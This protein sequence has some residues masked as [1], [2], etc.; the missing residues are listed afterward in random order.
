MTVGAGPDSA[1]RRLLDWVA[2]LGPR[3]G[4]P[5]D[6]CR[7]HGWLY[8]HGRPAAASE[9]AEGTGLADGE[10]AAA[11]IWLFDHRLVQEGSAGRWSTGQDPW[12]AVMRSLEVRRERELAP[13][14]E[15]LRA[16]RREAGSD[17]A[18]ASRVDR[19]LA[20]VEDIAAIDAQAR[21]LP[22]AT[23]RR[24]IGAGGRVARLFD[25]GRQG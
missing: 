23:L 14:L 17:P 22:P 11:L 2:E 15:V 16:S 9:I 12:E 4:L 5:A 24:L 6:A 3:W 25:R 10:V 13:A 7:A 20:L 21:R 1:R 8:L 18:L 19:L